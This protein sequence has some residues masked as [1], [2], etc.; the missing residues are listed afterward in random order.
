MKTIDEIENEAAD[1]LIEIQ[2]EPPSE[3]RWAEFYAWLDADSRHRKVFEQM[4]TAVRCLKYHRSRMHGNVPAGGGRPTV[5]V[6]MP[7]HHLQHS[8]LSMK[9]GWMV[10]LAVVLVAIASG[11]AFW[12]S[13]TPVTILVASSVPGLAKTFE[14]GDGSTV[15]LNYDTEVEVRFTATERKISLLRGEALFNVAH[16]AQRTFTVASNGFA[17][18]ALGTEFLVRHQAAGDEN[19]IVAQGKVEVSS[20]SEANK[21]TLSAGQGARIDSGGVKVYAI[22]KEEMDR[23]LSWV[24]GR[25]SFKNEPLQNVVAQF[26][27]Y[28]EKRQLKVRDAS[29]NKELV[30]GNFSIADLDGFVDALERSGIA[31]IAK[32]S[33]TEILLVHTRK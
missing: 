14:L 21:T 11:A 12:S 10:G 22:P 33:D 13:W 15:T 7:G 28:H 23:K 27:R 2:D 8:R 19:V 4:E 3:A 16:D 32:R 17:V 24:K 1:W 31:R 20:R 30:T 9:T 5:Q 18:R 25:L 6:N 29:L 26:N